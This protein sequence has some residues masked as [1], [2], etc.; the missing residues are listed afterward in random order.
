MEE[1]G[2]RRIRSVP[3]QFAE[4]RSVDRVLLQLVNAERRRSDVLIRLAEK[5]ALEVVA[6]P[7]DLHAV[8]GL[9]FAE[10]LARRKTLATLDF[11]FGHEIENGR[12]RAASEL[13]ISMLESFGQPAFMKATKLARAVRLST[14][15]ISCSRL[16][17]A[18]RI[19]RKNLAAVSRLPVIVE[20]AMSDIVCPFP[21]RIVG[22]ATSLP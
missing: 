16:T 2:F 11:D 20:C 3:T 17:P 10:L 21:I 5:V 1:C 19:V 13:A 6:E 4:D 14:G 15:S 22:S 9:A 12:L 7:G 18:L 8:D